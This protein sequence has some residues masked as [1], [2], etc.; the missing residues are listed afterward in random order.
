M[1]EMNKAGIDDYIEQ[2]REA[3]HRSPRAN[4]E[5]ICVLTM[6]VFRRNTL[7]ISRKNGEVRAQII[8][9]A[10]KSDCTALPKERKQLRSGGVDL[11]TLREQLIKKKG[12]EG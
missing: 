5:R 6:T 11:L 3:T 9:E 4:P 8:R 12:Y 7:C 1:D 10:P 2:I